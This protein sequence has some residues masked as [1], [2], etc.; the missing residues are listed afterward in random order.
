[1]TNQNARPREDP[2]REAGRSSVLQ[3][4]GE[5]IAIM[6]R[7]SDSRRARRMR[8][9]ARLELDQLATGSQ[10]ATGCPCCAPVQICTPD[11]DVFHDGRLGVPERE[12]RGRELALAGWGR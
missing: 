8:R 6:P 12:A 11:V 4:A 9:F 7:Q 1:V 2:S 5:A 10:L 3:A